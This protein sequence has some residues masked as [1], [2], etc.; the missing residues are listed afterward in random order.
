MII[1]G[2]GE[3]GAMQRMAGQKCDAIITSA[4][5][6]TPAHCSHLSQP[7]DHLKHGQVVLEERALRDVVT[8]DAASL[9]L[10]PGCMAEVEGHD[11]IN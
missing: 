5:V 4:S 2:R 11:Q 3:R 7:E 6:I 10:E 8:D 9:K 1:Q